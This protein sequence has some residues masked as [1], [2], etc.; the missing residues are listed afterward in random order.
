MARKVLVGLVNLSR[1]KIHP[2]TIHVFVGILADRFFLSNGRHF[3]EY[4]SFEAC[5]D[6]KFTRNKLHFAADMME[7]M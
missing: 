3:V 6:T 4:S 2:I 7:D 5:L 1:M